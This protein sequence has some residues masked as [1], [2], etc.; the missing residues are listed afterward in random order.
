MSIAI[1]IITSETTP[2]IANFL[3]EEGAGISFEQLSG[4]AGV[5]LPSASA[6]PGYD[7]ILA[8]RERLKAAIRA[9]FEEHGIVALAFPAIR[10]QPPKI[11]EREGELFGFGMNAALGS[12]A[13]LAS[14]VLPAGLTSNGL[15]VGM[16]F[17]GLSGSDRELL[18]LGQSLEKALGPIPPPK[19]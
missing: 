10:I 6:G 1:S 19:I 4:Q 11:G 16:E 2:S 13:S 8:Q 15:P 17:A 12:C 18:G 7:K 14:L 5:A 3:G 9:F